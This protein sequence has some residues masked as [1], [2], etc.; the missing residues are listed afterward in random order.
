[1][2]TILA[3]AFFPVNYRVI[4]LTSYAIV[5]LSHINYHA[6]GNRICAFSYN[7]FT[8]KYMSEYY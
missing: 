5:Q 6:T 4:Q 3:S 7:V 1:M 2:D 8:L